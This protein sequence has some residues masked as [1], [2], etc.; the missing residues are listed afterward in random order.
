MKLC[1]LVELSLQ[2]RFTWLAE[3]AVAVKFEGADGTG[4]AVGEGDGVDGRIGV[5]FG[6]AVGVA[7]G[8]AVSTTSI[9]RS[10]P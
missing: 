3:T 8:A 4:D 6:V 9:T 5:A 1:S 7:L 2:P 10:T